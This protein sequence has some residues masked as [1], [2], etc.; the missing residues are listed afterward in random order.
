MITN[1]QYRRW[2]AYMDRG[3]MPPPHLDK[4]VHNAMQESDSAD[5]RPGEYEAFLLTL[6]EDDTQLST[7]PCERCGKYYTVNRRRWTK[8]LFEAEHG[9]AGCWVLL[10]PECS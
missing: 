1:T 9:I 5:L 8:F 10:C 3:L 6:D 4:I 2:K 7:M